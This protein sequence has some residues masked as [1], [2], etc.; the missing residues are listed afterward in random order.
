[1]V[2]EFKVGATCLVVENPDG[3]VLAVSRKGDPRDFGLPGG[4]MDPGDASPEAC[5]RRE[6]LEETGIQAVKLRSVYVGPARTPGRLCEAFYVFCRVGDPKLLERGAIGWVTWD[7]LFEGSFGAYN[8][9]L[10]AVLDAL[11]PCAP[12]PPGTRISYVDAM[13]NT[14]H[15]EVLN[16]T[17]HQVNVKFTDDVPGECWFDHDEVHRLR[18]ISR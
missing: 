8:R 13:G 6:L 7:V 1:M 14:R 18:E 10:K 11:P 9:T 12:F 5:A 2:E 3:L 16:V 17:P 4:K 15:G